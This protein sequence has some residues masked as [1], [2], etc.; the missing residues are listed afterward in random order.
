MNTENAKQS[1][2][3][4]VDI[5]RRLDAGL[6]HQAGLTGSDFVKHYCGVFCDY[7]YATKDDSWNE[8]EKLITHVLAML[9]YHKRRSEILGL[10]LDPRDFVQGVDDAEEALREALNKVYQQP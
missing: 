6:R 7:A 5:V 9:I 3:K 10:P 4:T 2:E 1:K 8:F